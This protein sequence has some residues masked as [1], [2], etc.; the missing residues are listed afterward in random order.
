MPKVHQE[1]LL[2]P[3]WGLRWYWGENEIQI[4]NDSKRTIIYVDIDDASHQVTSVDPGKYA[5]YP[6][7]QNTVRVTLSYYATNG[8][9]IDMCTMRRLNKGRRLRILD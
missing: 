3:D 8:D 6:I 5:V 4:V 1:E 7:S 9:M 2:N